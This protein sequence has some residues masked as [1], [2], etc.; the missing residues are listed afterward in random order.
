MTILLPTVGL[1]IF[2][3]VWGLAWRKRPLL[4]FGIFLGMAAASILAVLFTPGPGG[5]QHI[6]VWLPALPFAIVALTLFAFGVLAWMWG[7][8]P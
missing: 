4:G 8:N 5:I 1:L 6:P 3:V 2:L 7:R